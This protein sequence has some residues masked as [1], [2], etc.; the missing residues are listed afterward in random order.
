MMKSSRNSFWEWLKT[1]VA[2][3]TKLLR[4]FKHESSA[5]LVPTPNVELEKELGRQIQKRQARDLGRPIDT[6][7]G[8]HN[9]PKYQPCP[10]CHGW[11]RR[12]EKTMGGAV[13]SCQKCGEFFVR[14]PAL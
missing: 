4:L 8:G 6:R 11:K 5:H 9:M 3:L 12:K 7:R 14:A 13:Y 1:M 10:H 2:K